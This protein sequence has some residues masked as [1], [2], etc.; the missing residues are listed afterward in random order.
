MQF[1]D[2]KNVSLTDPVQALRYGDHVEGNYPNFAGNLNCESCHNPGTYDVPDQIKSL[3]GLISASSKFA[4]GTRAIPATIAGQ[5]TGPAER[6]CG[7]CHR[8]QMINEDDVVKLGSFLQHTSMA[9]TTVAITG[10]YTTNDLPNV[11]AVDAFVQYSLGTTA[12]VGAPVA[13]AQI[14]G[15]E[16]CHTTAGSDHQKLFNVWRNG[17]K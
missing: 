12:T 11:L 4:T 3:P 9:G 13:G 14:E 17:T 15:C 16:T 6:A 10:A 1:M 2:I 8:A 7:G 5:I